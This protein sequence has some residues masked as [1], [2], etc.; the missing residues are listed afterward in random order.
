[1]SESERGCGMRII[2]ASYLVA[3]SGISLPCPKMPYEL[4]TCPVCSEGI[5]FTRSYKWIDAKKLTGGICE[6]PPSY[7]V[8]C[9]FEASEAM[10]MWVGGSFYTPQKFIAEAREMG[11][12]KRINAIPR[13]IKLGETWVLLAHKKGM[14]KRE[15][16]PATGL[17][18]TIDVT[19]T[20][21]A[22]FYAFR[23]THIEK[24]V[25]REML[26]AMTSEEKEKEEKRGV[27]FVVVPDTAAHRRK[28]KE[29]LPPPPTDDIAE[30]PSSWYPPHLPVKDYE[31]ALIEKHVNDIPITV[32]KVK[33]VRKL[34]FWE[35]R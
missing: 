2:G 15:N 30:I 8:G 12:S 3:D 35:R 1:M 18:T 22:I 16:V 13:K 6:N 19:T 34:K 9:P 11:I 31:V 27:K 14:Q 20:S 32:K 4:G 21:P 33:K 23:P 29:E 7:C 17:V 25:T 5:S 26:D 24:I 28:V 10:L